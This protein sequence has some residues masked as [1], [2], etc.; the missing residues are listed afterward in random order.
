MSAE[1]GHH[2]WAQRFDGPAS[3]SDEARYILATDSGE[4]F[5]TGYG[6][7]DGTGKDLVTIRDQVEASSPVG[8][9]PVR[10]ITA[11]AWPNPF[12]PRVSI[13]FELPRTAP[14]LVVVFDTRG[15]RVAT[16]LEEELGIGSHT[17]VWDGRHSDGRAAAAGT[18]LVRVQSGYLQSVQKV[19]LAK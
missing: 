12:N 9:L 2:L 18:Y 7:G 4:V 8:D 3:Q 16:L 15:H 17:T 1:R 10:A 13:A 5:V 19:V 6:Y 14:T 11:R